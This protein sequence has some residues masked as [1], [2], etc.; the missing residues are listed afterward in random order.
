LLAF[1]QETVQKAVQQ[2]AT[3]RPPEWWEIISGIL[4]IPVTLVGMALSYALVKKTHSEDAKLKAETEKLKLE[5]REKKAQLSPEAA[6]EAEYFLEV[7]VQ[8]IADFRLWQLLLLRFLVLYILLALW[9]LVE[10]AFFVVA[11]GLVLGL[12]KLFHIDLDNAMHWYA[13]PFYLFAMAPKA[14]YWIVLYLAGWPLLR[15]MSSALGLSLRDV[16]RWKTLNHKP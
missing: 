8:P 13:Y 14:G 12:E 10:K 3:S 2:A 11:M 6:A 16:L 5:V 1:W 4:A 9:P 7:A 15:D